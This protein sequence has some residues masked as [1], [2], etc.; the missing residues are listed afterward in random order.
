MA[1]RQQDPRAGYVAVGRVVRPWGLR[2][3]VKV[4]SL[5]DF[6]ERFEPGNTVWVRGVHRT[7][8][9]SR[10]HKG[11]LFVKL[12]GIDNPD[13]AEALRGYLL[14]VA[15]ADLHPL[16]EGDFYHFQ[17]EGLPVRTLD[18]E[19]LGS[20]AE[21]FDSGA[22]SVLV[23]RG[24]RGE[25]LLPFTED[26]IRRVDIDG[27]VVEVELMEGLLPQPPA[28]RERRRPPH[29]R[30]GR[31]RASD[32]SGVDPAASESDPAAPAPSSPNPLPLP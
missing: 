5:T 20:I 24:D 19:T 29:A 4:E 9:G 32:I 7:V 23:L 14:E 30:R 15:E 12:S 17:L 22:H 1:E 31:A 3:H 10:T 27:G 28:P 6:V 13:A 8:E 11:E 18:G 25:I 26:V 16:P 2:G 21:V